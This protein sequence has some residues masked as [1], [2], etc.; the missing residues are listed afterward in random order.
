MTTYRCSSILAILNGAL[1]VL[2][3]T[4]FIYLHESGRY[5][6]ALELTIKFLMV[7]GAI[8][9]AGI[10]LAAFSTGRKVPCLLYNASP[11]VALIIVVASD[12]RS[13]K[14]GGRVDVNAER[15]RHLL[16]ERTNSNDGR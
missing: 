11:L 1:S 7:G 13:A 4:R 2:F 8:F 10:G 14:P 9:L 15:Q 12:S 16:E 3:V 6:D 5:G